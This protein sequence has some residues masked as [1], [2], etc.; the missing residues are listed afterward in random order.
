MNVD[1]FK[2]YILGNQFMRG[3]F[4]TVCATFGSLGLIQVYVQTK[5]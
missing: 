2:K 1:F 4:S 5:P 3:S